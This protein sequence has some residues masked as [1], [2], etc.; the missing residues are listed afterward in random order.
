[1]SPTSGE[2]IKYC[3]HI[4]HELIHEGHLE[5][6]H[7]PF[8]FVNLLIKTYVRNLKPTIIAARTPIFC[9]TLTSENLRRRTTQ[10]TRYYRESGGGGEPPKESRETHMCAT[11]CTRPGRRVETGFVLM[12]PWKTTRTINDK[13]RQNRGRHREASRVRLLVGTAV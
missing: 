7:H 12:Y 3:L 13:N 6:Y 5:L 4:H 2:I 10:D 1:M 8:V 9:Q 11:Y